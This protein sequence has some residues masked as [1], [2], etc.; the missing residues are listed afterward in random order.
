TAAASGLDVMSAVSCV[1]WRS[2]GAPGSASRARFGS[3]GAPARSLPS[4]RRWLPATE[5]RSST[6]A[7]ARPAGTRAPFVGG[8]PAAARAQQQVR[9]V[10]DERRLAAVDVF[11]PRQL[12]REPAVGVEGSRV[13]ASIG[14]EAVGEDV[15]PAQLLGLELASEAGLQLLPA[16]QAE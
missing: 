1:A 3:D 13:P 7:R 11:Q 10:V 14:A 15:E 9:R 8:P 12:R 4:P 2:A 6:A 5:G 16:E